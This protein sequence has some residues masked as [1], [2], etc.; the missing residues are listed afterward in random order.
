[1]QEHEEDDDEDKDEKND[2]H[3]NEINA[4]KTIDAF[5]GVFVIVIIVV[6][7]L[8]VVVFAQSRNDGPV[9]VDGGDVEDKIPLLVLSV[10]FLDDDDDDDIV[11]DDKLL[12]QLLLLLSVAVVVVVVSV[13]IWITVTVVVVVGVLQQ[14]ECVRHLEMYSQSYIDS[15]MRFRTN[16]NIV[17]FRFTV[18]VELSSSFLVLLVLSLMMSEG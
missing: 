4:I 6:V 16:D 8:V 14:F 7:F 17:T 13:P 12:L 18:W 2:E 5:D 3:K 9:D 10:R 1:M 11:I 15:V